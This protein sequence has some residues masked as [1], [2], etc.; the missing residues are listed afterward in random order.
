M[1]FYRLALLF[2]GLF[3]STASHADDALWRGAMDAARNAV[4][5]GNYIGA[6]QGYEKA[7]EH[8]VSGAMRMPKVS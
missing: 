8:A 2:V 6:A 5:A 7:L 4:L 1:R 3:L